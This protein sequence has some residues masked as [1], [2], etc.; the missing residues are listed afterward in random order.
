GQIYILKDG[1]QLPT[2]FLDVGGIIVQPGGGDERG[3]LGFTF[4]PDYAKNGRFFIY[5]TRE[6]DGHQIVAEY[7]RSGGLESNIPDPDP[8][9][10]LMD[11]DDPESNHNGG[12]LAFS[13]MDGFLYIGTGDGGGAGDQHGTFGNGQNLASVWGKILR[14]DVDS[15]QPYGIPAGNMT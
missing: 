12:N 9:Q 15:K 6:S 7:K 8:V 2:P 11:L 1:V 3:L 10:Q 5:Y 4:H 13:P 14:V